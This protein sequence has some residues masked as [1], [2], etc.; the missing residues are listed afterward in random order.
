MRYKKVTGADT[1]EALLGKKKREK[2]LRAVK[3]LI[4]FI[5]IFGVFEACIALEFKPVYPVYLAALCVLLL[6]FLFLNRG[7]SST[8]PT[9]DDFPASW[10]E[11]E[12][13]RYLSELVKN[14][15]R[16]QALL[17]FI[18]PLLVTFL[19]DSLVLFIPELF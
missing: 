3:L 4:S 16:A 19:I 2:I 10:T 7:F 8:L 12:K 11:A 6:A 13:E 15:K 1:E 18:I 5:L 9:L 17:I 14:K